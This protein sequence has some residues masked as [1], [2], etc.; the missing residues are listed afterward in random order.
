MRFC[1]FQADKLATEFLLF[2]TKKT[3]L[4]FEKKET[5]ENHY[6]ITLHV[7]GKQLSKVCI[8]MNI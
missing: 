2:I 3:G 7:P 5:D 1:H 4:L 6:I 8:H